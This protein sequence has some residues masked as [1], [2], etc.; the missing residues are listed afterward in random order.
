VP[1]ADDVTDGEDAPP[2][3]RVLKTSIHSAVTE[4]G[5]L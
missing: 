1:A 2:A 3:A 5:S 4:D